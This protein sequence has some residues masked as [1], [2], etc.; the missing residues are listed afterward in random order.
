MSTLRL[1]GISSMATRLLLA[2]LAEAWQQ[3]GGVPLSVESV[4]GV[5]AARRVAAGEAFDLVVLASDAIDKLLA[6]GHAVAGSRTDLVHSAVAIAIRAGAP[7]PDIGSEAALRQTLQAARSIGYS[8]G[9]SGTALLK[10]FERWGLAEALR[11]RLVQAPAGVPVGALVARC[12]VELGFQQRS[13]LMHLPG[14]D[15]IGE[16]PAGTQILTT[17][18]AALCATSAQAAAVREL[19]AF[20]ASPELAALKRRHGFEPA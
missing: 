20:L 14:I 17:F 7:R 12:E 8:T 18:S 3:Q 6:T 2:D 1:N 4:G 11:E 10:L 16:M 19:L 9:P 15:L 5:D 13:E